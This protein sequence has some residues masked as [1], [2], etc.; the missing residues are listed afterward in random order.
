MKWYVAMRKEL[1]YLVTLGGLALGCSGS[2]GGGT[3]RKFGPHQGT[4]VKLPNDQGYVEILN[5][6]QAK[7]RSLGRQG[8]ADQVIVYFLDRELKGPSS[9]SPSGVNVKLSIVTGKPAES[10]ALEPAAEAKDPFGKKRFASK[11][12]AYQ[13]A[14][15]HGE[16]SATLDGQPFSAEFDA[17][18]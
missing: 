1:W 5:E 4:L 15:V 3:D 12:G 11:A 13:L 9:A 14:G 6:I 10:V 2:S 17:L 18:R 7:G 16:L 8:S